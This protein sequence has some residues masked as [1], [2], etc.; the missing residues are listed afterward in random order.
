MS[1][2]SD[3]ADQARAAEKDAERQQYKAYLDKLVASGNN[4]MAALL[5]KRDAF[6]QSQQRANSPA[7]N[8]LEDSG[9]KA[10]NASWYVVGFLGLVGLIFWVRKPT[11]GS[12]VGNPT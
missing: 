8:Q 5:M 10:A 3:L 2:V 11:V 7:V 4:P 6:L 9:K 12:N 1:L